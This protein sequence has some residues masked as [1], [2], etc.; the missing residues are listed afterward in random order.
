MRATRDADGSTAFVYLPSCR[1]VTVDL[2]RLSG[3][4]IVAHWFD[5]RTG[6]VRPAGRV[7]RRGQVEFTP[8]PVW[9]DWVLVLDDAARGYA[10]PGGR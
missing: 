3:E 1:P 9:P 5:P 10:A 6:A 2:E 4:E 7:A 8:P